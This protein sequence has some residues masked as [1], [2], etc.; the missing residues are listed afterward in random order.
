MPR[1]ARIA[2]STMF[3][4]TSDAVYNDFIREQWKDVADMLGWRRRHFFP[5]LPRTKSE[6]DEITDW[7]REL[8][9]S[10]RMAVVAAERS[11]TALPAVVPV[12]I[13]EAFMYLLRD[14]PIWRWVKPV[15]T[16][17]RPARS[18]P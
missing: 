17:T 4:M 2:A 10:S 7:A 12:D 5:S 15:Q 13:I 8:V 6:Y 1:I 14:K 18:Q 11:R 16:S 3:L 9:H